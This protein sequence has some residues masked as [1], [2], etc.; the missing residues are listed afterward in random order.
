MRNNRS[1]S[2]KTLT[3]ALLA[4]GVLALAGCNSGTTG[5]I[6][7]DP[8]PALDTTSQ[9]DYE[10][11][12]QLVIHRDTNLRMFWEDIGRMWMTDRPSRLSP[13]PIPY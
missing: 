6:Y 11:K 5:K 1:I 12:N 4:G 3:V 13:K 9:T 7:S 8:T 2:R 10:I